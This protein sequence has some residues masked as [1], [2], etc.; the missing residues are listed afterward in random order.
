MAGASHSNGLILR[1]ICYGEPLQLKGDYKQMN[2]IDLLRAKREKRDKLYPIEIFETQQFRVKICYV[3]YSDDDDEWCELSDITQ[4]PIPDNS[5]SRTTV[6]T[7]TAEVVQPY[8]LYKELGLKIKQSLTCG[9]K[10]SL[11]VKITMEFDNFLF[12]GGFQPI[13]IAANTVQ[14]TVRYKIQHYTDLDVLFGKKWQYRGINKHGDYSYIVLNSMVLYLSKWR[15]LLE[16]CPPGGLITSARADTGNLL[17]FIF[18]RGYGNSSTF[19]K[20]RERDI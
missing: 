10:D 12:K 17:T 6:N 18:Q 15:G 20:E 14:G 2:A 13:G 8:S 4:L 5:C 16:Y 11:L 7:S 9:R 1:F 19:G 3:G